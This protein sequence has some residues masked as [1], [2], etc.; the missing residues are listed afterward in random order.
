MRSPEELRRQRRRS[1]A[2]ALTLVAL[3]V[4]FYI[5]TLVRLGSNVAQ[6]AL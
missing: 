2:I 3:V 5:V 1:I 6:R 4:I